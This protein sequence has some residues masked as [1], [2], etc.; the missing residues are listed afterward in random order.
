MLSLSFALLA[1]SVVCAGSSAAS[2]A[3]AFAER[4]L[5]AGGAGASLAAAALPRFREAS[6]GGGRV[7]AQDDGP[8]AGGDAGAAGG[9]ADAG[10]GAPA[11]GAGAGGAP[12]AVATAGGGSDE[13]D[14]CTYVLENKEMQQPYLCRGL[15]TPL[16]QMTCVK[17]LLSL[18]WWM[19][20]EVYCE[21]RQKLWSRAGDVCV[22]AHARSPLPR[23]A[24]LSPCRD[25]L[26]LPAQRWW[27]LAVG[28]A[29]L[30]ACHLLVD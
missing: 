28:A 18:I 15:K 4:V 21:T 26:R 16:Q 9:G 1:T 29:V 30:A 13:C 23:P 19:T 12:A 22:C 10:G 5:A 20:N 27:N 6:L 24:H 8:A 7:W 25:K 3:G 2:G 11:A 14:V 17:V